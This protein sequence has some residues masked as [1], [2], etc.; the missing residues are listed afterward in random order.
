MILGTTKVNVPLPWQDT[1]LVFPEVAVPIG[2]VN[3]DGLLSF[4]LDVPS[5]RMIGGQ[6]YVQFFEFLGI[7][8]YPFPIASSPGGLLEVAG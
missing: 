6:I 8:P 2:R 1:L 4:P 5:L 7:D 3:D